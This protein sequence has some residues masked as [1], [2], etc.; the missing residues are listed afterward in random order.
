MAPDAGL[1]ENTV[2][3]IFR[4]CRVFCYRRALM[5][6]AGGHVAG[7]MLGYRLPPAGEAGKML[8]RCSSLR[9]SSALQNRPAASYYLNTLAL[10]PEDRR[11]GY[12]RLLLD[13]AESRARG[14]GCACM[15]LET[16]ASNHAAIRFYRRN[17]FLPWASDGS[18]A[19]SGEAE[20][21]AVAVLGKWLLPAI[22]HQRRA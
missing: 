2:E 3:H 9:P 21:G 16:A 14:D 5:L 6:D 15:L 7:M 20:T 11:S 17:G 4:E 18:G 8:N 13:A 19:V 10:Y 12:G 1:G 22:A